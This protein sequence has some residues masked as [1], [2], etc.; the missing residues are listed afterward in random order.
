MMIRAGVL[1]IV[2][3]VGCWLLVPVVPFLGYSGG[4]AFV[5]IA[6]LLILAEVVFWL[7]LV[8]AGRETWKLA[9]ANGWRGVPA[10]LW[11]TLR[12]GRRPQSAGP[13]AERSPSDDGRRGPGV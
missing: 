4:T 11:Q 5:L 8:L 12:D 10:A 6:G 7:G 1:L 9:K 13:R 3:S 2:L